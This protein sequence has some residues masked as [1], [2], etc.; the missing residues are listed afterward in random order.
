M[1]ALVPLVSIPTQSHM[2]FVASLEFSKELGDSWE[3]MLPT[4]KTKSKKKAY[5]VEVI[6]HVA[7]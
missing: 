5:M 4:L 3:E 1:A 7:A 6:C 2:S